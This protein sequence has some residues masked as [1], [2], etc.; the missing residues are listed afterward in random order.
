MHELGS[1]DFETFSEAGFVWHEGTQKWVHLPGVSKSRSK[2]L[3]VVGTAAYA[4]HPTTEVLTL[5]YRLPGETIKHRW[6]PGDPLPVRL[7]ASLAA[8]GV[9]KAH[10]FFFE[11]C[12]WELVCTVKYGWPSIIPWRYQFRCTMAT[13]RTNSLPGA[14]ADLSNVLSLPIPKDAAG[15]KL[16]DKFSIPRAP[17]KKDARLRIT[18]ED[19]PADAARLEDYCDTDLDAE[20]GAY[21]RMVPMSPDELL[22]WWIDQE[23]NWRGLGVDRPAVRDCIAVLD[24][25]LARYGEEFRSLTGGLEPTQLQALMGWLAAHG[26][27]MASMDEEAID[28]ALGRLPPHP[29]GGCWPPRRVLEIRQLIGSAS[30]KKLYQ[31]ENTASRDDRVRNLF[32]HHGARTGRPTGEGAQPLNMPRGGP[33]MR[34]CKACEKPYRP[35]HAACPWCSAPASESRKGKWSHKAVE[36]VLELMQARSLELVEYYCGDALGCIGGCLRGLFVAGPGMQL[37]ASDYS[38]IETVVTAGLAGEQWRLDTIASGVDIYLAS[39][40]KIT[41]TPVET[42]LAYAEE[43]GEHHPDR[44]KIG[45]VN[46]LA[47]LGPQTQVWT[48][49][50]RKRR[51]WVPLVEVT[52]AHEVH[53]GVSW[54]RHEGLVCRGVRDVELRAGVVATP[55]H[56]FR[57]GRKWVRFDQMTWGPEC[58]STVHLFTPQ[59]PALQ[60]V[61]PGAQAI[62]YDLLNAGPRH[63]FVIASAAGAVVAHNCGFGGWIGASRAFGATEPDDVIKGWILAWR[64]ASPAIVEMWGGQWRG[65]PWDPDARQE[66]Y[67]FEGMAVQAILHPGVPFRTH[68]ITFTVRP[69]PAGWDALFVTLPSGR[70]LTYHRPYLTQSTRP[71][72]RQGEMSITYWTQNSNPK[73]GPMGWVPMATFGGRITENCVQAVAHDIQRFGIIALRAAGYPVVLHVYDEDCAEIPEGIGSLEEFERIMSTMPDYAATWPIKAVGGWQ[74]KRYRKA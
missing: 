37:M 32:V 9:F 69:H 16:L 23:I 28:E 60:T 1:L 34:Y 25:A 3:G 51:R 71:Y 44:Q 45:K 64:K 73:Y 40:S 53:D 18:R 4:E 47:C 22:F 46:E 5:S 59:N 66:Y 10:N 26:V 70:E 52:Q 17:T 55:E 38:A 42:Y 72:A 35:D 31:M 36:P 62:V 8:G 7:F 12:I 27:F 65:S 21:Q 58:V 39:A 20:E 54:V 6:R 74:G 49:D 24:Q 29:L 63:R 13:A 41:G 11:F 19:D 2:G 15:K 50:A 33:D 30:V 48:R 67:G 43:H 57:V 14:L 61:A 68:G 56:L